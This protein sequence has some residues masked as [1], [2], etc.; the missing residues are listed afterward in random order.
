MAYAA[1]LMDVQMPEMGG[2]EATAEI[3][4]REGNDRHTPII[5]MTANAMSSDREAA[6]AVGMDD[7]IA[8][9]V[10]AEALE[11]IL[12]NWVPREGPR[13]PVPPTGDSTDGFPSVDWEVIDGLRGIRGEGEPDLLV[14]LVEIFREDTPARI[15]ALREALEGGDAEGLRLAAHGLKG[16]S[17]SLG[18]RRM[19]R[20]AE[21]VEA[22]ARSGDLSS[23]A[24]RIPELEVEF[25]RVCAELSSSLAD[26]RL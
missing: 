23:A 9:P 16:G 22:V 14:E 19:A 6:L 4:R 1:I 18:A 11:Q 26:S 25:E 8:K 12:A 17:G 24:E 13:A 3:R 20:I 2:Y 15:S 10:K 5:A 21:R 7:Y